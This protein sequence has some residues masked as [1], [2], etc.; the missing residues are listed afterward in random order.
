MLIILFF[1]VGK[2]LHLHAAVSLFDQ[3][4]LSFLSRTNEALNILIQASLLSSARRM[5]LV[6][7]ADSPYISTQANFWTC[8]INLDA[9]NIIL[10]IMVLPCEILAF[11]YYS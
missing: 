10:S 6:I 7:L 1:H 2:G 9:L 5:L 11:L 8:N 3:A 4:R